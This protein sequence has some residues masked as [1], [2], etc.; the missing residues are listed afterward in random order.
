MAQKQISTETLAAVAADATLAEQP[1]GQPALSMSEETA[2]K[3]LNDVAEDATF[4]PMTR[5]EAVAEIDDLDF[6]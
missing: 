2:A 4:V 1:S 3:V 6:G 5:D